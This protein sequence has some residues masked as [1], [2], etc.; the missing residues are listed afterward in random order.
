MARGVG[1]LTISFISILS[2]THAEPAPKGEMYGSKRVLP[3]GTT[4]SY[5]DVRFK[6]GPTTCAV[7]SV[8]VH[9]RKHSCIQLTKLW[10][11]LDV[12]PPAHH[13]S[14]GCTTPEEER[15]SL[16]AYRQPTQVWR[17]SRTYRPSL[18][19]CFRTGLQPLLPA[20]PAC[21]SA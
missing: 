3:R 21:C 6:T 15:S 9:A 8:C 17:K 11:N 12:S 2:T 5:H 14:D 4:C 19:R 1:S 10:H 20:C 7:C 18:P 13:C 16:P